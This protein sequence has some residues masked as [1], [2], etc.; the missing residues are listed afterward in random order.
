VDKFLALGEALTDGVIR[1]GVATETPGGSP[2]NVAIG[3]GRLNHDVT[4]ATRFGSDVRGEAIRSH[5]EN[6]SVALISE[7]DQAL[8]T[9]SAEATISPDGSAQYRFDLNW[10]LSTQMV[11]VGDFTHVHTGSIG[12]TLEPGGRA[13]QESITRARAQGSSVSYDPNARPI[14]MGEAS[15]VLPRV[16]TLISLSDVVKASD[17]DCEWLYPGKPLQEVASDWQVLGPTLVV[18]T[19]GAKGVEAWCGGLHVSLPTKA[20]EIV[21][22]IGAGDSFMSGLLS[23][24]SDRARLGPRAAELLGEMIEQDLLDVLGFALRCAAITVARAGANPPRLAE[25]TT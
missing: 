9:S 23:A 10:D 11:P 15:G 17:E 8:R 25:V 24:L 4:L 1:D 19:Q 21:D 20:V 14:I 13:V 12:A 3:L 22:T 6:S 7:G 16:E 2:L 18:I 5:L